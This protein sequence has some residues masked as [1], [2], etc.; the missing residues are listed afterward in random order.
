MTPAEEAVHSYVC[1]QYDELS[2]DRYP[3]E[4]EWGES[5]LFYQ[6][7]QWLEKDPVNSKVLRP[8][9]QD[10][11]KKPWPMPVSNYFSQ[12][13]DLNANSLGAAIPEMVAQPANY[14][15]A[16]R[17]AAEAAEH[18][19]DE[20]NRESGF[21]IL[22]PQLALHTALFGMGIVKDTIN[23]SSGSEQV[24]TLETQQII[25][26]WHCPACGYSIQNPQPQPVSDEPQG[27]VCPN[28]GQAQLQPILDEHQVPGNATTVPTTK[29]KT[30]VLTPFEVY[31]LRGYDPN[32][33]P[34]VIEHRMVEVGDLKISYPDFTDQIKPEGKQDGN[35]ALYYVRTLRRLMA[36]SASQEDNESQTLVKTAWVEWIRLPKDV[37]DKIATEWENQPS[38]A[39]QS[40]QLSKLEAAVA[41]GVFAVFCSGICLELSENPYDGQKPYTFFV[42]KKDPASPYPMGLGVTLKPLQK[43]LN[44]LDS[45]IEKSLMANSAGKWIVPI[46][47]TRTDLSAD[48]NDVVMYDPDDNKE[49]PTFISTNPIAA[50]CFQRRQVIVQEFQSL[51]YTTS[52]DTGDIPAS[53]P[54]RALAFAGSKQDESRKTQRYLWELSHEL[55]ARKLLK[56]AKIA[57][58]EPRKIKSAGYNNRIGLMMLEAA[59]LD[60]DYDVSVIQDSSRPKT[61]TEKIQTVSTLLQAGLAD[62]H[63]PDVREYILDTLGETELDLIDHT[64]YVKAERDL[65]MLK[66]GIGPMETPFMKWDIELLVISEYTLT[67]EF[68][69]LDPNI[70]AHILLWC[71][72]CQSQL[73]PPP[74]LPP[75]AASSGHRAGKAL[76]GPTP[77]QVMGGIPGKQF[78]A[79][80]VQEA[81]NAEANQFV[82][83]LNQQNATA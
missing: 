58:S 7:R 16:N 37:Q 49:R 13:I 61:Q 24:S 68:E 36:G 2:R 21:N 34:Q 73:Q 72:Y 12:T 42:W 8:M 19:I 81:A 67:E 43:Q 11:N 35:L 9:R 80:Q 18:A 17:R 59:D 75:A 39:Y 38:I 46:N 23:A 56:L 44:R 79:P 45:L 54:F 55:R 52:L 62:P 83:G 82:Q 76:A 60:G 74:M 28:C 66:N 57:W 4:R 29:I 30:E 50:A 26:G 5:G 3:E 22:N 33:S 27:A 78:G 64:A 71:Q 77:S 1:S 20:A 10:S 48:P 70:R 40:K 47:Q 15:Q 65:E 31:V 41:Y 32:Q 53:A 6:L 51:G 25:T 14:D 69:G 63:N